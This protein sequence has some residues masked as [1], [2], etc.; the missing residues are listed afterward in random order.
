M[1]VI[2][3]F[4]SREVPV[5][6][7]SAITCPR[8]CRASPPA[9]KLAIMKRLAKSKDAKV[10]EIELWGLKDIDKNI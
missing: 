6:F 5:S 4:L 8:K 9:K 3:A 1:S 7:N 10:S 2:D